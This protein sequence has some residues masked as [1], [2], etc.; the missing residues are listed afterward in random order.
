MK[1][2]GQR[3]ADQKL[4]SKRSALRMA[5]DLADA[6]D[7][8]R[9]HKGMSQRELAKRSK[10]TPRAVSR[11]LSADTTIGFDAYVQA[12]AVFGY[13]FSINMV[14]IEKLG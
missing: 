9:R 4:K 14:P 12:W 7:S 10:L 6:I 1:A 5:L 2:S 13:K 11:I 3:R 8:H